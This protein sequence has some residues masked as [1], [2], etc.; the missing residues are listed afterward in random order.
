MNDCYEIVLR[1]EAS[2]QSDVRDLADNFAAACNAS[3]HFREAGVRVIGH[4]VTGPLDNAQMAHGRY[5][6]DL[7]ARR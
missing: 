4:R 3:P 1:V 2:R 5:L 7:A 6:E